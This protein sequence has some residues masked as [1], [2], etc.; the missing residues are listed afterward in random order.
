VGDFELLNEFSK[1]S[2]K[3]RKRGGWRRS[4]SQ[5]FSLLL[6]IFGLLFYLWPH[7]QMLKLGDELQRLRVEYTK[8]MEDSSL[9]KVEIASLKSP[10]RIEHV[11]KEQLGMLFPGKDQVMIINGARVEES[12]GPDRARAK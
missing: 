10:G 2:G 11:A 1:R 9:F 3:K 12:Y 6:V 8:E 4:S 7:Y 5:I